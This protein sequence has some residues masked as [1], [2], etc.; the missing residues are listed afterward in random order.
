M[1]KAA[2][3][4]RLCAELKAADADLELAQLQLRQEELKRKV[5]ACAQSQKSARC[6]VTYFNSILPMKGLSH[7]STSNTGLSS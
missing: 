4:A 2:A 6:G 1:V 3:D 7:W 5:R